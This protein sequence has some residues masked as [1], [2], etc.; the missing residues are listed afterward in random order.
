MFW[1]F[2]DNQPW[3]SMKK[4]RQDDDGEKSKDKWNSYDTVVILIYKT[5]LR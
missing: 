5:T 4:K 3:K 1:V 2:K